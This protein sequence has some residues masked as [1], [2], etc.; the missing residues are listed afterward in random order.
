VGAKRSTVKRLKAIT[1]NRKL[2]IRRGIALNVGCGKTCRVTGQ[3]RAR[4]RASGFAKARTRTIIVGRGKVTRSA[5]RTR[6]H[7]RFTA[8]AR[9]ELT[10]RA[11]GQVTLRLV[12]RY[13][14]GRTVIYDRV[15]RL[16]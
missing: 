16:R 7:L 9:R 5:R 2:S 1:L 13:T 14:G 15:V 4:G 6:V 8:A 10:R 3:L 11:R 12:V